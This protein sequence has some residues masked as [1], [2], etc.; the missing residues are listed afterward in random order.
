MKKI[1]G[2]VRESTQLQVINGYNLGEQKRKIELYCEY[3]YEKGG[4]TLDVKEERGVSAKNLKR[5]QMNSIIQLI[6]S[7]ELDTLI[8]HNLDRLTRS[9]KDLAY[10]IEILEKNHIELI[11]I[12]ENIDTSTPS[13]RMFIMIIGV[14]S[15]W[16][17]DSI[18][19]R[20]K[21]GLEEAARR[22]FYCKGKVP[23]G[24]KRNPDDK[25]YL[26]IDDETAGVIKNIFDCIVNKGMN[27]WNVTLEYRRN[28]VLNRKWQKNDIY[29]IVRNLVYSGTLVFG[30][31][32]YD[33]VIPPIVDKETQLEAIRLTDLKSRN[34][35]YRYL[36]K[37]KILCKSCKHTLVCD[38]SSRKKKQTKQR[39][40]YKYYA[41]KE[42]KKRMSESIIRDS[43]T[44]QLKK[45]LIDEQIKLEQKKSCKKMKGIDEE[46]NIVL[47]MVISNGRDEVLLA[48][49]NELAEKRRKISE[50]NK[51]SV[52]GY[53]DEEEFS[54]Y[55]R[56]YIQQIIVDFEKKSINTIFRG[57][58]KIR[59]K[60]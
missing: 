2:Y 58:K 24:Y 27:A 36:F 53:F 59:Q 35:R 8:I 31:N 18:S 17:E 6:K 28:K 23:L 5:P 60:D 13:G 49:Y 20:T 10:L 26:I 11:S 37:G 56:K 12:T 14:I 46:M 41:C 32:S 47:D 44:G 55:V 1:I 7:K 51:I 48:R 34:R 4:Y 25:H 16:E 39:D 52:D 19:W 43:V 21:R 33:G 38:C 15:Q 9:V 57:S 30:E 54:N 45:Y 29:K 40:I 42:C 22:G 3:K 50:S